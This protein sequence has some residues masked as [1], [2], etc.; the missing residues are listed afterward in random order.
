MPVHSSFDIVSWAIRV[1]AHAYYLEVF[2]LGSLKGA[3][4]TERTRVLFFYLWI[5]GFPSNIH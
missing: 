4:V 2:P 1:L 5:S 3:V